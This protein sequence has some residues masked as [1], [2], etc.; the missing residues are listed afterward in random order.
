MCRRRVVMVEDRCQAFD[1][2]IPV[3]G[4]RIAEIFA[5]AM[6][7][8]TRRQDIEACAVEAR[9]QGG[10]LGARNAETVQAYDLALRLGDPPFAQA[11]YRWFAG[12]DG[13]ES[14]LAFPV[15]GNVQ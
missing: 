3:I 1:V 2:G 8:Q 10:I 11:E 7:A 14:C 15:H 4:L 6:A 9:G 12:D 5:A 13:F